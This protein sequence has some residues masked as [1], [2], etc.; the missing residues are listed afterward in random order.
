MIVKGNHP[1]LAAVL[2]AF[3][4]PPVGRPACQRQAQSREKGH[5]RIEWRRLTTTTVGV[6][7]HSRSLMMA[8]LAFVCSDVV[9]SRA[10]TVMLES[11]PFNARFP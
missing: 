2:P 7:A 10:K 3:F 1:S 8:S 11:I 6:S 4:E 5:G 9:G